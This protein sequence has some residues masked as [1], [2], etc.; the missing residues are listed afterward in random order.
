MQKLLPQKVEEETDLVSSEIGRF[1][2]IVSEYT[3]QLSTLNTRAQQVIGKFTAQMTEFQNKFTTVMDV[4]T[5]YQASYAKSSEI[6]SVEIQRIEGD[7]NKHFYPK[8]YQDKLKKEG[9]V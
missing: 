3:T 6:L 1:N 5:R 8:H 2:S 9:S 7:Y 4:W